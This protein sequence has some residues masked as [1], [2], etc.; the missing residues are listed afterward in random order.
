G[1]E[2]NTQNVD[3]KARS[4]FPRSGEP[5]S[6]TEWSAGGGTS[7]T[8]NVLLLAANSVDARDPKVANQIQAIYDAIDPDRRGGNFRVK[9]QPALRVSTLGTSLLD[10]PAHVLHISGHSRKH[11]GLVLA[12]DRQP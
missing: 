7:E 12:G 5:S 11:Q 1:G 8:L 6:Q 4:S 3:A 10:F 2:N 9:V